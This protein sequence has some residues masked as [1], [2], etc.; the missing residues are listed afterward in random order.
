MFATWFDRSEPERPL[1]DP[2]TQGILRS[3]LL[4]AV[5]MTTV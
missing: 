3:K 5:S 2:V 1:F 4:L